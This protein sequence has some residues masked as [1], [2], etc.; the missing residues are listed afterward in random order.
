MTLKN[1]DDVEN[2]IRLKSLTHCEN[3][4]GKKLILKRNACD[5]ISIQTTICKFVPDTL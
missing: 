1:D 4:D 5:K 2:C 3:L